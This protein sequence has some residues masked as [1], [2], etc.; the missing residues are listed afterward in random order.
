MVKA[1]TTLF[2]PNLVFFDL[3]A[4]SREEFFQKL[5]EELSKQGYIKDTWYDAILTREKSYPTGLECE[6]IKVAIPHTDPEHLEKPY[7]AVVKPSKPITFDFMAGMG[8]PV[9]AELIVNLGIKH[10]GGQVEI[11]QQLMGIFMNEE[12]VKEIMAQTTQEGMVEAI[13][14]YMN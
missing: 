11:L 9:D 8:D 13:T 12:A 4:N 10:E 2:S 5:G 14:K 3:E 7:I 6:Q 1:D